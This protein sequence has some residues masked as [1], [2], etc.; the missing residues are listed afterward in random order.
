[1]RI[2][3]LL[4]SAVIIILMSCSSMN[5]RDEV[6][7]D[8]FSF[9]D[10]HTFDFRNVSIKSGPGTSPATDSIEIKEA[11]KKQMLFRGITQDRAN[12]DLLIDVEGSITENIQTR[13]KNLVTDPPNYI[14]QRR[15]TWKADTVVVGKYTEGNF[16][17]TILSSRHK[18]PVWSGMMKGVLPDNEEKREKLIHQSAREL[19]REN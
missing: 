12:P 15:Y 11:I 3:N 18:T 5:V 14:G 1:M 13:K 9:N 7:Q 16:N 17:I 10:Y 6:L 8:D 19:F 2:T 4:N